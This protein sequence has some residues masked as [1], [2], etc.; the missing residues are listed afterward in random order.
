MR[1]KTKYDGAN[2]RK[3][4]R[5]LGKAQRELLAEMSGGLVLRAV[6]DYA[7]QEYSVRLEDEDK[8]NVERRVAP[9][10][11]QSLIDRDLLDIEEEYR[12]VGMDFDVMRIKPEVKIALCAHVRCA[13][14]LCANCGIEMSD[15]S[16]QESKGSLEDKE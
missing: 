7:H 13:T 2:L 15:I 1:L 16:P 10:L 5:G 3:R 6:S 12:V 8:V 9:S 11:M 4:I 14:G